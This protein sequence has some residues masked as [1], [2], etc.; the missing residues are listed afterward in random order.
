MPVTPA[1]GGVAAVVAMVAALATAA[2]TPMPG[3]AEIEVARARY[4]MGTTCE[5]TVLLESTAAA[6]RRDAAAAALEAAFD[7]ISRLERVLSDWKQD[8]ELSRVNREAHTSPIACSADL[9]DFLEV[10]ARFSRLT[11]GAFDLTLAPLM[12]AYDL[13]GSG[14]W[15]SSSELAAARGAVGF[16]RLRLDPQR[17]TV[18]FTAPGM[19]LDP[20]GVGKGYALDAAARVLRE[21]GFK[22]ALLDFGGQIA[23]LGAP[24]GE[25]GW[26]VAISHPLR[27]DEPAMTLLLNDASLSTSANAERGLTVDGRTL[28]HVIDPAT[29]RPVS[30]QGSASALARSG[31]EADAFSTALMVMGPERGLAWAAAQ[32]GLTAVFLEEDERGQ[33]TVRSGPGLATHHASPLPAG[34]GAAAIGGIR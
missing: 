20:G 25:R 21:R 15:P 1:V 6:P 14:R 8:S 31:A 18:R 23:A 16:S 13:R 12:R 26:R 3:P 11:E 4:L 17:R 30:W 28:G 19:A 22:T 32:K 10:S 33:L 24:R 7:E 5:G 29:G 2:V 9:Y 27:R 34:T